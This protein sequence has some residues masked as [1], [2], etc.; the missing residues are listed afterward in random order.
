MWT[1]SQFAFVDTNITNILADDIKTS[2]RFK[3]VHLNAC[4]KALNKHFKFSRVGGNIAN[5]FK[6]L[7]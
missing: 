5:R 1:T 6:T 2:T 7:K 4:T 3:K